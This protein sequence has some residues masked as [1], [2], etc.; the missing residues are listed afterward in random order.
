MTA[1]NTPVSYVQSR[2]PSVA[3]A[4]RTA[5]AWRRL[6]QDEALRESLDLPGRLLGGY[7]RE[8]QRSPLGQIVAPAN[9]AAAECETLLVVGPAEAIADA[10]R[11][12]AACAHPLHNLL[13]AG[14]RAGR[15]RVV[16]LE[17]SWDNDLLH[18]AL[19][20]VR[21]ACDGPA[22]HNRWAL[23]I[24]GPTDGADQEQA[25]A[26]RECAAPLADALLEVAAT[27][28]DL[29]RRLF[30]Q[31]ATPEAGT[32]LVDDRFPY[33]PVPR[34][35]RALPVSGPA[36]LAATAIGVDTVSLLKGS[37]WFWEAAKKYAA[38][39]SP[40][41]QLAEFARRPGFSV[42]A[43]HHGLL[44]VAEMLAASRPG[45]CEVVAAYCREGRARLRELPPGNVLHLTAD[46]PRRDRFAIDGA[47]PLA[48]EYAKCS[49]EA[50]I[51]LTRL[52]DIGIGE[53]YQ[54]IA[55]AAVLEK[56]TSV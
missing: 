53:L 27:D 47:E 49:V 28:D 52:H 56:L 24:I 32:L 54:W 26:V 41:V 11:L 7:F 1:R 22:F 20:L 15:S 6:V 45:R 9:T 16:L 34:L 42:V 14:G 23:V 51:R 33:T 5:A 29:I 17:A 25:R 31:A 2:F 18:A 48:D 12:V 39:D 30:V 4:E 43:W 38:A 21:R 10:R 8:R 35:S 40:V 46:A 37:V 3:V 13:P 36:L 44:P 50:E 55:A 19:D